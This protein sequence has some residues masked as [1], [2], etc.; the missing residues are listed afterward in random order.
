MLRESSSDYNFES[1]CV[2]ENCDNQKAYFVI[3]HIYWLF[4]VIL[5]LPENTEN[6]AL[7]YFLGNVHFLDAGHTAM[8]ESKILAL[9][10]D[11]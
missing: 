10:G 4:R 8:N 6:R 5:Y 1:K 11:S 9:P 3:V 2:K 7:S